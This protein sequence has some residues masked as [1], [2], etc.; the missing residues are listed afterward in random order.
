MTETCG[1]VRCKECS[2]NKD[3]LSLAGTGRLE[4]DLEKLISDLECEL[5]NVVECRVAGQNNRPQDIFTRTNTEVKE[6]SKEVSQF[7]LGTSTTQHPVNNNPSQW[8]RLPR[9]LPNRNHTRRVVDSQD[10]NTNLLTCNGISSDPI[11]SQ[12]DIEHKASLRSEVFFL[13]GRLVALKGANTSH[14]TPDNLET[15]RDL[16]AENQTNLHQ[17]DAVSGQ[18]LRQKDQTIHH[19]DVKTMRPHEYM[20][21][22]G[23]VIKK[24]D[25]QLSSERGVVGRVAYSPRDPFKTLEAA[26]QIL[27]GGVP[28]QT[29]EPYQ[30]LPVE[31]NKNVLNQRKYA[32]SPRIDKKSILVGEICTE[33]NSDDVFTRFLDDLQIISADKR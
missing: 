4:Q 17:S 12:P 6:A 31:W 11:F 19:F 3:G 2:F 1:N 29:T 15:S 7:Q 33:K 24:S 13:E 18:E 8:D 32:I 26:A 9:S 27:T 25:S 28:L 22:R 10:E 23:S 21:S 30:R 20:T 14:P 5:D 16:T